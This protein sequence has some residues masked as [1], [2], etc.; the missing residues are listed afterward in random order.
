MNMYSLL[1]KYTATGAFALMLI[2]SASCSDELESPTPMQP[3]EYITFYADME[4]NG[5]KAETRGSVGNAT[6]IEE[7]WPLETDDADGGACSRANVVNSLSGTAHIIAYSYNDDQAVA[8]TKVIDADY[9]FTGGMLRSETVPQK[10][11]SIRDKKL[12]VYSYTPIS[13][14]EVIGIEPTTGVP[15]VTYTVNDNVADQEDLLL[16]DVTVD[17]VQDY[18]KQP[19]KL[20]FK[21]ALSAIRFKAGFDCTVK[22]IVIDGVYNKGK[23]SLW[24][25]SGHGNWQRLDNENPSKG[26]YKVEFG[27]GKNIKKDEYIVTDENTFILM[28]QTLPAG[29]KVILTLSD[30]MT[31][32]IPLEHFVWE[33]G[34]MITYTI[35]KSKAPKYLYFDLAAGGVWIRRGS[36][37]SEYTGYRF[38]A[39]GGS[40]VIEYHGFIQPGEQYYIYQSTPANRDRIWTADENGELLTF[41]RPKYGDVKVE[42]SG[43][44]WKEFITNNSSVENVIEEWKTAAAK[45]G[46]MA[47]GN[48]IHV[49]GAIETCMMTID[50]IY[51]SYEQYDEQEDKDLKYRYQACIGYNTVG[52]G[53]D[54]SLIINIVGDN[55]LGAIQFN[56][57]GVEEP[58]GSHNYVN[59]YRNKLIFRGNGSL[60][61]A[62][63][64]GKGY[65]RW[66]SIIGNDESIEHCVGIQIDGGV[67]FAGSKREEDCTAIGGGGNG[68][69][70][71]TINGGVV[72]AVAAT[73]G[74]AI[75]GG[76]G[77]EAPGGA[78]RVTINGGTVY[79]YN[80]KSD[81][82]VPV[83]AIGGAG[84]TKNIAWDGSK[85]TI[86]GGTVYAESFHGPAI[87]AGG[88][89]ENKGGSA[90]ITITGGDITAITKNKLS[91]AIGGGSSCVFNSTSNSFD[92]GNATITISGNPVI[93]TGSIGGGITGAEGSKI[94]SAKIDVSGG[95]IQGQFILAAGSATRPSFTMTGG[96]INGKLSDGSFI[97]KEED[98]G[99]V[100]MEDGT[101]TL[102]DG[103][104]E[105][106]TG[107]RGGAVYLA[108][109]EFRMSGGTI[110]DCLSTSHGG[111]IFMNESSV[112]ITGGTIQNNLAYGGD[113]GGV[114]IIGNDFHMSGNTFLQG[115]SAINKGEI[116]GSGGAVYVFSDKKDVVVDL[117]SGSIIENTSEKKGGGVCVVINSNHTAKVTVGTPGG[118]NDTP[119]ISRNHTL[120]QGAGLHV[121]GSKADITIESGKI[122][123]NKVG[124]YVSNN[125][126]S[127]EG[128]LV[129]LNGGDVTHNVI[130]FHANYAGA[131]PATT[132]Q[133]VVTATR[134][135]LI[136]P[137]LERRGYI[138][139]GWSTKIDGTGDI[140]HDKDVINIDSDINLYAKWTPK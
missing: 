12:K 44:S 106:C 66:H 83:A 126:V 3:S 22:S 85:V 121:Q 10:W 135:Q 78:G 68:F 132:Q 32:N 70:E 75:G 119:L 51:S 102:V 82:E 94:G 71:V 122:K 133:N 100:Y 86:T 17:D 118:S 127:N 19:L 138:F 7:E 103:V 58:I 14:R 76:I 108:G 24:D 60:T 1:N 49:E 27:E 30:G 13:D 114:Y 129:A 40:T 104:I 6:F 128:G 130:T 77:Y 110:R 137:D 136:A 25:E 123:D 116:G 15:T 33:T 18:K 139:G 46:M 47:T 64:Q 112:D 74:T 90:T 84:S 93:R 53:T 37:G 16:A 117:L 69:G 4:P 45:A 97:R 98:G 99:A 79:A 8:G 55:R 72:T 31:Y 21:H 125:D 65:N 5:L 140:Y 89:G 56:N 107:L 38:P 88:S 105:N 28:P 35:Y 20:T 96:T 39:T 67:I 11:S 2:A 95:T 111:A 134:S 61:V 80:H 63:V 92:G 29:A 124:A 101:F 43:K 131:D 120:L 42:S 113:G 81:M 48:H 36:E 34:T 41:T 57:P 62:D 109:G 52:S 23:Y 9:T 73:S 87:G 91:C 54:N 115:N 50:N 59:K 26:S